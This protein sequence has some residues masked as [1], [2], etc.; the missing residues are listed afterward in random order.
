[1]ILYEVYWI[2]FALYRSCMLLYD[3]YW[4][5]FLIYMIRMGICV[6]YVICIGS[7]LR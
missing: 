2:L 3:V 5:L 1:M 7:C 6:S 4:M